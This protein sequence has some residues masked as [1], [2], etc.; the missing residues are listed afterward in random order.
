MTIKIYLGINALFMKFAAPSDK[1][2]FNISYD[3]IIL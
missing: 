2:L 3:L 1:V